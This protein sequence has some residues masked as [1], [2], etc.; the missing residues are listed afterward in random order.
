MDT[1]K[2]LFALFDQLFAKGFHPLIVATIKRKIVVS[3]GGVHRKK[4]YISRSWTIS[5]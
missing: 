3:L 4:T 5:Y 1:V 2:I